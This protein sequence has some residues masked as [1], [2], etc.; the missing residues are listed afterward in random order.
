MDQIEFQIPEG[1]VLDEKAS[2]DS[3]L[4]YKKQYDVPNNWEEFCKTNKR[5]LCYYLREDGVVLKRN[6]L[7]PLDPREDRNKVFTKDRAESLLTLTQLLNIRD[8]YKEVDQVTDN[9]GYHSIVYCEKSNTLIVL[10]TTNPTLFGFF[11]EDLAK[12]FLSNFKNL[13]LKAIEFLPYIV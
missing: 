9:L 4:V 11:Q 1:Y 2:T 7:G 3:K 13:L 10:K 12:K 5:H 8:R 6:L